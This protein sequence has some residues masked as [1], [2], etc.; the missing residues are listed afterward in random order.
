LAV[1]SLLAKPSKSP[2][3]ITIEVSSTERQASF[4]E[5]KGSRSNYND[6][7]TAL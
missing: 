5:T 2:Q 7:Q 3:A 6:M 1:S 4:D